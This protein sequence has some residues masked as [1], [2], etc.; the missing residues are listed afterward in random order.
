MIEPQA[1]TPKYA[2]L[3]VSVVKLVVFLRT[4]QSSVYFKFHREVCE[5][6]KVSTFWVDGRDAM[7]DRKEMNDGFN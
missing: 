2:L 3:Y 7:C 1:L 6:T 5:G 4:W